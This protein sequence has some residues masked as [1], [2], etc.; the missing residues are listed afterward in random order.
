MNEF[1]SSDTGRLVGLSTCLLFIDRA[2]YVDVIYGVLCSV[3]VTIM[4]GKELLYIEVFFMW[5]ENGSQNAGP[6]NS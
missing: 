2:S 6:Q 1:W 4:C 5:Y 3:N